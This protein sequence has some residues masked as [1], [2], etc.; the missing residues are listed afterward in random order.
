MV[1]ILRNLA[2]VC[3][4][5]VLILVQ[6]G[7]DC[8][9]EAGISGTVGPN[10]PSVTASAKVVCNRVAPQ[11]LQAYA[12]ATNNSLFDVP[13]YIV[14]RDPAVNPTATVTATTD[15]GHTYSQVFPLV[16]VDPSQFAPAVSGSQ[17]YAFAPQDP[18]SLR[19]WV[20]WV[21]RVRR[22]YCLLSLVQSVRG[23]SQWGV[24]SLHAA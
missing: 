2:G 8:S 17:T 6:L 24:G 7:C 13:A 12:N 14:T 22:Y 23:Y 11:D 21:A 15:T 19:A 4:A 20:Q 9:K 3:L 18:A 16:S 5:A 1:N 10:G